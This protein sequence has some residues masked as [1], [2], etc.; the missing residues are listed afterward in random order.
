MI[1]DRAMTS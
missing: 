1:Q